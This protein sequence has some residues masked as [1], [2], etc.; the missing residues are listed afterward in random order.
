MRVIRLILVFLI[1]A[2]L[3]FFA[4]YYVL[5][6]TT[7]LSGLAQAQTQP[8]IVQAKLARH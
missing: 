7:L 8:A 6:N 4:T 2:L 3:S 5:K 1:V